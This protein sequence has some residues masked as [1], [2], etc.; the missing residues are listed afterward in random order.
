[1]NEK[2]KGSG[3]A[4]FA[5]GFLA[6]FRAI[7][8][9]RER[10]GLKGYFIIPFFINIALLSVL[11]W[12]SWTCIYP[13]LASLIPQGDA[14]YLAV[15]RW[16]ATPFLLAAFTVFLVLFYSIGG[17]SSRRRSTIRSPPGWRNS[18]AGKRTKNRSRRA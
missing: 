16:M 6:P 4:L 3:L 11:A 1:M 5:S 18:S 17:A 13:A 8:L 12:F 2:V 7:G 10:K 14:W 15:L 9:V